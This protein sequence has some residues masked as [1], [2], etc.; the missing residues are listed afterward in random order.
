[1]IAKEI[2]KKSHVRGSFGTLRDYIS[3]ARK[4]ELVI[5]SPEIGSLESAKIEMEAIAFQNPRVKNPV[6]HAV[7]SWPIEDKPSQREMIFSAQT[8]LRRLDLADHQWIASIHGDTEHDH[9][10]IAAN[11]VH[12]RTLAANRLPYSYHVLNYTCRELEMKKGWE[13]NPGFYKAEIDERGNVTIVRGLARDQDRPTIEAA[14]WTAWNGR[15]SFQGWVTNNV[16]TE[17]NS[18]LEDDKSTVTDFHLALAKRNLRFQSRGT[19]GVLVDSDRPD[20]FHVKLSSVG[21][22]FRTVYDRY[23]E[24]PAL[25]QDLDI[26]YKSNKVVSYIESND[27]DSPE[28]EQAAR[29]FRSQWEEERSDRQEING[30]T[31]RLAW[32]AQRE[33]EAVRLAAVRRVTKENKRKIADVESLFERRELGRIF[34]F[35]ERESIQ[36]LKNE[37]QLER[38]SIQAKDWNAPDR[39]TWRQWLEDQSTKFGNEKAALVL[40]K[41]RGRLTSKHTSEDVTAKVQYPDQD[42]RYLTKEESEVRSNDDKAREVVAKR[43]GV[44]ADSSLDIDKK[45]QKDLDEDGI[46]GQEV[47]GETRRPASGGQQPT[48]D[49]S[50]TSKLIGLPINELE[51]KIDDYFSAVKA[52]RYRVSANMIDPKNPEKKF[53]VI[54]DKEGKDVASVGWTEEQVIA[55]LAEIKKYEARGANMYFTPLSPGRMHHVI[56]DDMMAESYGRLCADGYQPTQVHESSPGNY[57]A[58]INVRY[59]SGD[60]STGPSTEEA[61][62]ICRK[63]NLEY[64]DKK[65]SGASHPHRIP[66][67]ANVKEK[68]RRPDGTYPIVTTLESFGGHVCELSQ[69]QYQSAIIEINDYEKRSKELRDQDPGTAIKRTQKEIDLAWN[70]HFIDLARFDRHK[71]KLTPDGR[72]TTDCE[73]DWSSVDMQICMRMRATGFTQAAIQSAVQVNSPRTRPVGQERKKDWKRYAIKTTD[74]AFNVRSDARNDENKKYRDSWIALERRA[75]IFHP[76]ANR[77]V[78][79]PNVQFPTGQ[80]VPIPSG[81]INNGK[82]IPILR[83]PEAVVTASPNQIPEPQ[84]VGNQP[85]NVPSTDTDRI[86]VTRPESIYPPVDTRPKIETDISRTQRETDPLSPRNESVR[87]PI[88]KTVRSETRPEQEPPVP[89]VVALAPKSQTGNG[90]DP[91]LLSTMQGVFQKPIFVA[92]PILR[93]TFAGVIVGAIGKHENKDLGLVMIDQGPRILVLK[94]APS[95]A[96]QLGKRVSQRIDIT[97]VLLNPDIPL[98]DQET[99]P[100]LRWDVTMRGVTPDELNKSRSQSIGF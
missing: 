38:Q 19:G 89:T 53:V 12:P 60:H 68:N 93:K 47:Q 82:F 31:L 77:T 4:S 36:I 54:L 33:S 30:E 78:T 48:G 79:P 3:D 96:R 63:L 2:V 13:P 9:I 65:F 85:S 52:D 66:G 58:I 42:D 17:I 40:A 56:V 7:L 28:V 18:I 55:N 46:G 73:A 32:V 27:F 10:H 62:K 22:S 75:G 74:Y 76:I 84:R 70:A 20:L 72:G 29:L 39:R 8:V 86:A 69:K 14:N 11:R 57:Q 49:R 92:E 90:I 25:S 83:D 61:N 50:A 99:P 51:E 67:T 98:E 71:I 94:T 97:A 23:G 64:G 95:M 1:M 91:A 80:A 5:L 41:Y 15:Q 16:T 24:I 81:R 43:S 6:Y 26:L 45:V 21:I 87:S 100:R 34:L 35:D 59:V 88:T 37:F 44:L